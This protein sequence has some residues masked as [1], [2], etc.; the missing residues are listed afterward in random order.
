MYIV[1]EKQFWKTYGCD[2]ISHRLE[3]NKYQSI[4]II[5]MNLN[6]IY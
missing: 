1:R 5:K 6:K 4:L 3:N 2:T